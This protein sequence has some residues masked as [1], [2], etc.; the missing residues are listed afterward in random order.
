MP[1]TNKK[2]LK[3]FKKA[4]RHYYKKY[5]LSGWHVY[6]KRGVLDDNAHAQLGADVDTRCATFWLGKHWTIKITKKN[7]RSSA[8]HEMS[9]L[10]I[11]AFYSAGWDRFVNK[12][13]LKQLNEELAQH[14]TEIL[15]E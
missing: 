8:K 7:L 14:L 6:C 3:V 5:D 13:Q 2:D 15:P 4:V 11:W 12:D 1:K 10:I 9:H